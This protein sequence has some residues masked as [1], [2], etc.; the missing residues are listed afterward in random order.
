MMSDT[1]KRKMS[2]S[3][4]VNSGNAALFSAMFDPDPLFTIVIT[5]RERERERRRERES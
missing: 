4:F 3:I 1:S 2:V 5:E